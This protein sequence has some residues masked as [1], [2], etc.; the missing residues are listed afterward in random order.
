MEIDFKNA[1]AINT[2]SAGLSPFALQ[3]LGGNGGLD[4]FVSANTAMMLY[5]LSDTIYNAVD[6]IAMPFSQMT[7]AL[8][9]KNN[10]DMLTKPSDHPFLELLENPGFLM[11][12]NEVMYSLMVSFLVASVAYPLLSGNVNFEP[13]SLRSVFP[14]KANLT[15]DGNNNLLNISFSDGEDSQ[16]Y[17]RQLIPKRKT[18]VYQTDSMLSETMQIIKLKRRHGIDASSPLSRLINQ[19]Y[20]KVYGNIHNS[21]MLKNG[22]RPGGLWSP[23]AKTPLSPEQYEA[24]KMEVKNNFSGPNNA[25]RNVVSPTGIRYENFLLNTRDMDFIKLIDGSAVDIYNIYHIPLALVS[26]E[27]MTMSNFENSQTGLFDLAVLPASYVVLKRLGEFALPRYKDGDK[28]ELTFD[29]KTLPALRARMLQTA[30]TMR[31]V[32]SYTEDE[33]RQATGHE[34]IEGGYGVYKPANLVLSG[35]EI[36]DMGGEEIEEPEEE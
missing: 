28:Y 12:S 34:P 3:F 5:E 36:D 10:G 14:N 32:G 31:E 18:A 15:P 33:I 21:N 19:V 29:E 25:A 2:K 17:K 6:L 9:D 26:K 23:D 13:V 30:K 20:T 22:S 11:S 24:F 16:L 27:T 7:Y 35:E 8:R 4:S 1:S